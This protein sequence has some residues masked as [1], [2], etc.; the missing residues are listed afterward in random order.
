MMNKPRKIAFILLVLLQLG[1]LTFM[2]SYQKH[3]LKTGTSILLECEPIDPR[4]L[5]SGDY[6][7]LNYK[8]HN[9]SQCIKSK[10]CASLKPEEISDFE[11]GDTIYLALQTKEKNPFAQVVSYSK[12]FKK[13]KL[14]YPIIIKSIVTSWRTYRVSIGANHY[15][16]PQFEGK[17][18]EKEMKNVSAEV[19][20]SK[21]GK[22][23]L[24]KLF[25]NNKEVVFK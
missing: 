15:Y 2:I 21:N 18:I 13:L 9:L 1:V 10:E 23:A 14:K 24:K 6:V 4:S 5:F 8:I 19:V 11:K 12:N 22:S 25:I 17:K 20:I 16:V 3:L 7:I